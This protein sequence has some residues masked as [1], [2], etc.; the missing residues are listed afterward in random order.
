VKRRGPASQRD[1]TSEAIG[2]KMPDSAVCIVM[3]HYANHF[4]KK[5]GDSG[6]QWQRRVAAVCRPVKH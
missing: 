1:A 2:R 3:K 5:E 6:G 4:Q